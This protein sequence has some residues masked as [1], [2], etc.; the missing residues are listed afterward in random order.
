MKA[1]K[2]SLCAH[3][4]KR[5]SSAIISLDISKRTTTTLRRIASYATE[6]INVRSIICV[7]A[8][9]LPMNIAA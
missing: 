8:K 2:I 7:I 3:Y 1:K 4:A 6:I 5:P 9:I